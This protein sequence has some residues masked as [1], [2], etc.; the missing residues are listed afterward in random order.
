MV[1][2][3]L[4]IRIGLS[5]SPV[6]DEKAGGAGYDIRYY[7]YSGL[8]EEQFYLIFPI[9]QQGGYFFFRIFLNIPTFNQFSMESLLDAKQTFFYVNSCTLFRFK[10]NH[11]VTSSILLRNFS[12]LL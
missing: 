8:E 11:L 6:R 10:A 1:S 9:R 4:P 7:I 5:A 12:P 3:V 2:Q